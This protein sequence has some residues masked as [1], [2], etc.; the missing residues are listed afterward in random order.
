MLDDF[1]NDILE[2]PVDLLL[3]PLT[4]GHAEGKRKPA[5]TVS[6]HPGWT[7]RKLNHLLLCPQHSLQGLYAHNACNYGN[8][9][10]VSTTGYA[11]IG[12]R[13]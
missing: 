8:R 7:Q 6:S 12:I 11:G 5:Q 2:N 4:R 13:C 1:G 3:S 10:A 9:N